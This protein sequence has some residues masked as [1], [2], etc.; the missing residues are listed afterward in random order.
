MNIC[1]NIITN[2]TSN[3]DCEGNI[4]NLTPSLLGCYDYI[5]TPD[6]IML[7][8]FNHHVSGLT[9]SSEGIYNLDINTKV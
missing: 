3:N 2:Y 4:L 1:D 8:G 7:S 5:N 9:T 6:V